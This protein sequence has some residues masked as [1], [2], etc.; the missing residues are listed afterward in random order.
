[1][2][3]ASTNKT[4]INKQTCGQKSKIHSVGNIGKSICHIFVI[5][6]D[7]LTRHEYCRKSKSYSY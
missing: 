2:P 1:M 3:V 6:L 4:K 7:N 5:A